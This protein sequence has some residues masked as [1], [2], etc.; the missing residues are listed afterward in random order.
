MV[1]RCYFAR[2]MGLCRALLQYLYLVTRLFLCLDY[3]P[4]VHRVERTFTIRTSRRRHKVKYGAAARVLD[5][6]V[7]GV[8][9]YGAISAVF[10]LLKH[11]KRPKEVAVFFAACYDYAVGVEHFLSG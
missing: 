4:A 9:K 11:L 1:N 3:W 6:G 10:C 7:R 2:R 5:V 8:A